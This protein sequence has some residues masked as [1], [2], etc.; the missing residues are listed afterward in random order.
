MH[1]CPDSPALEAEKLGMTDFCRGAGKRGWNILGKDI[2]YLHHRHITH[3]H[4]CYTHTA[5]LYT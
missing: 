1:R 4:I 2:V 3:S 5:W